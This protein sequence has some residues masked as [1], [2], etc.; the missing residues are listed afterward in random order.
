MDGIAIILT[1]VVVGAVGLIVGLLLVTAGEK[2]KV[3]VD[4]K[5]VAVRAELPGNNCGGCGYPGCD[6]L[7]AAIAKGEARVDACPVGGASCAEKIAQIMG[8]E[9]GAAVKKVAYVHCLGT[10]D[11]AVEKGQYFGME[12]CRAAAAIPGGGSKACSY[13]CKGLGSCVRACQFGAIYVKDGVA[14]VDRSKCF[15]CGACVAVCPN[16]LIEIIPD[17][18]TYLVGCGNKDKAKAVKEVCK[19]GCLGCTLCVKQCESGS[20]TMDAGLAVLNPE[21]CTGC[22]K[23]AEKCPAKII[24]KREL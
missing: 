4:E 1:A 17:D 15:G 14:V 20:I 18:A 7:A 24:R 2:F 11:Q 10:C 23:C 5:E 13:G 19:V 22:G 9:V 12:D 16:H 21:T 3:E 8:Q 6:G